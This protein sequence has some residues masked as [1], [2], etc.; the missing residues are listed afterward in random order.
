MFI[1]LVT[2]EVIIAI[3]IIVIIGRK[4]I[5]SLMKGRIVYKSSW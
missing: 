4:S 5:G 2:Y 3:S 1:Y